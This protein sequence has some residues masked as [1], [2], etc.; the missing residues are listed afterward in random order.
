MNVAWDQM[1]WQ[2][3]VSGRDKVSVPTAIE[4]FN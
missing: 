2:A 3:L 4:L 1:Q